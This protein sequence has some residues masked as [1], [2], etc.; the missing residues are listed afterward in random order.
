MQYNSLL[1]QHRRS[2][3]PSLSEN[4]N[5]GDRRHG[6][7]GKTNQQL[8]APFTVLI[9]NIQNVNNLKDQHTV[10]IS[11]DVSR[12]GKPS[13]IKKI[14]NCL[15]LDLIAVKS[16]MSEVFVYANRM[17]AYLFFEIQ[18]AMTISF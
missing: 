8:R 11:K 15:E 14:I 10:S 17:W 1:V 5:Y 4:Y 18:N 13:L 7:C 12:N 16:L 6:Q 9:Q 2:H 3:I